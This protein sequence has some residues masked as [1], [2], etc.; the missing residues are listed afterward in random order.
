MKRYGTHGLR[1]G[2]GDVP[3]LLADELQL[4]VVPLP[5]PLLRLQTRDQ[6]RPGQNNQSVSISSKRVQIFKNT[7]SIA[8][9]GSSESRLLRRLWGWRW[10]RRAEDSI[11]FQS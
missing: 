4:R 10:P 2:E 9:L 11:W 7:S 1:T 6:I 3:D 8:I 5:L